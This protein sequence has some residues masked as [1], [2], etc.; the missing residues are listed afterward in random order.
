[1]RAALNSQVAAGKREISITLH[2]KVAEN[3]LARHVHFVSKASWTSFVLLPLATSRP[4][5]AI[6]GSLECGRV[7]HLG[8]GR[9]CTPPR[10]SIL[11]FL[12]RERSFG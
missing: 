6:P 10:G 11:Q 9:W 3:R 12:P 7:A 5:D 4:P 1:M 2:V 8:A